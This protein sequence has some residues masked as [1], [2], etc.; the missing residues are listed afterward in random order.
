MSELAQN[1]LAW[2]EVV[3]LEL[4]FAVL[5]FGVHFILLKRKGILFIMFLSS[6]L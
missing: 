3:L 2:M 6:F 1:I 4:L 5:S